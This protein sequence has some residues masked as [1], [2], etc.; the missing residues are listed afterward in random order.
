M[1]PGRFRRRQL[2]F[3]K[4]QYKMGTTMGHVNLSPLVPIIQHAI[5]TIIIPHID[6]Q[7]CNTKL[8]QPV[9]VNVKHQR[10]NCYTG[11]RSTCRLLQCHSD[12]RSPFIEIHYRRKAD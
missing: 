12:C 8:D 9:S 7:S 4:M 3:G 1:S 10:E 2:K 5:Y 11:T 6:D